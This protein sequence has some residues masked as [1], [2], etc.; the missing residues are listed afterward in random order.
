MASRLRLLPKKVGLFNL[1]PAQGS[2]HNRHRFGRGN[3]SG[4]GGTSGRGHKGQNARSGNGKPTP[5]FEGGQTPIMRKFPKRGFH[6]R[7]ERTYAPLNLDRLQYW[8]DTGR[9]P[10]STREN[11]LTVHHFVRSNCLHDAHDGVKILADGAQHLRTP[12]HVSVARAS[13]PA[14]RAIEKLGGSVVCTY[15]NTLALQDA[16]KGRT[17]RL[18]A[19]P[20]RREDIQW[21]T[22]YKNRGY[23]NK[24]VLARNPQLGDRVRAIAEELNRYRDPGQRPSDRL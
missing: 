11:P 22:L 24:T 7:N 18:S 9:L 6:N 10:P 5:G 23:L 15:Q 13:K 14:I 1:S 12:I 8:I 20:T 4:R 16:V 21:Y 19:A 17:D 3:G 2:V